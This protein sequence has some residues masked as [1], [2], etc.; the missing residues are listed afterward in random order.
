MPQKKFS[1]GINTDSGFFDLARFDPRKNGS[2]YLTPIPPFWGKTGFH[3]SFHPAGIYL[4]TYNPLNTIPVGAKGS[5]FVNDIRNYFRSITSDLKLEEEPGIVCVL[6]L[7]N[8]LQHVNLQKRKITINGVSLM[9]SMGI[10]QVENVK[11]TVYNFE[12]QTLFKKSLSFIYSMNTGTTS[13]VLDLTSRYPKGST[14]TSNLCDFDQFRRLPFVSPFIAPMK[15]IIE[16][17][18]DYL[19]LNDNHGL[20]NLSDLRP[21]MK[22]NIPQSK[23]F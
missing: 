12:Q 14:I 19:P 5:N 23:I 6:N 16:A 22:L 18:I 10:A 20:A 17:S 2:L 13:L 4:K 15:K 3:T 7:D 1:L 21:N 8:L 9:N 11:R